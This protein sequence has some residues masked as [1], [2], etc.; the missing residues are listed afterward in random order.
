MCG[1]L[2]TA[3]G[4]SMLRPTEEPITYLRPTPP[5]TQTTLVSSVGRTDPRYVLTGNFYIKQQGDV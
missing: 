3:V 4:G 1:G 5:P 2:R